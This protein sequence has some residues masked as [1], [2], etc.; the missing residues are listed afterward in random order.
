MNIW[1]FRKIVRER[2]VLLNHCCPLG[3]AIPP[4]AAPGHPRF[5]LAANLLDLPMYYC[6]GVASGWD[7]ESVQAHRMSR[8]DV[9][10]GLRFGQRM[11]KIVE[12]K[13]K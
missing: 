6:L 2:R 5:F 11:R 8:L 10:Q 4:S 3:A 7:G 13:P 9:Q 1:E 12:A